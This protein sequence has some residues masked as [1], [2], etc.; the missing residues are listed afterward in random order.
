M[1]LHLLCE[2]FSHVSFWLP[3][4]SILAHSGLARE[5]K[6]MLGMV[7]TYLEHHLHISVVLCCFSSYAI[8]L[9]LHHLDKTTG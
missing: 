4:L 1:A 9:L 6:L 2:C 8:F 3:Y 5:L 7:F